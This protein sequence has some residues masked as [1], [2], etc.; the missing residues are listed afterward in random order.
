M[1]SDAEF[2]ESARERGVKLVAGD[3]PLRKPVLRH[4]NDASLLDDF[5]HRHSLGV[6]F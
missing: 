3:V 2:A 1:E 5:G 6:P 4:E